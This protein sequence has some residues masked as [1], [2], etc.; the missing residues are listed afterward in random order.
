MDIVRVPGEGAELLAGRHLPQ[1]ER[2]V[3]TGGQRGTAVRRKRDRVDRIRMPFEG[4]KRLIA[5]TR[6]CRLLRPRRERPSGRGAGEERY[7]FA[8][9]Q[10][11][12]LHLSIPASR[13]GL[14]RYR[15]GED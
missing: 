8:T 7:E 4:A 1:L 14:A 11:I 9:L 2:A 13:I 12:G 5:D 3:V 15:I 6:Y 10:L